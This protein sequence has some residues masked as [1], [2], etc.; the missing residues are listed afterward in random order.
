M[1][2]PIIFLTAYSDEAMLKRAKIADPC[3]YLLKPFRAEE[4]KTSIEVALHKH[5]VEKRVHEELEALVKQATAELLE[6]NRALKLEIVEDVMS[7]NEGAGIDAPMA[8]RFGEYLYEVIAESGAPMVCL[9]A[10]SDQCCTFKECSRN[11]EGPL[12]AGASEP[13][14]AVY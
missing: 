11:S 5:R 4:L 9:D 3:G 13:C 1:N 8:R 6:P 7:L 2:L 10:E 14:V 12:G